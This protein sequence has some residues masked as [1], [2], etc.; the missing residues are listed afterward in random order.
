M[1]IKRGSKHGALEEIPFKLEK[2]TVMKESPRVEL[3]NMFKKHKR[4]VGS[5]VRQLS[6]FGANTIHSEL[7]RM[8]EFGLLTAKV[9]TVVLGDRL[10]A[11]QM[12]VYYWNDVKGAEKSRRS[13]DR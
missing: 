10:Q 8:T 13:Y 2:L 4:L 9:E 3:C 6:K 5:Q 1:M 7:R 12:I 11:K